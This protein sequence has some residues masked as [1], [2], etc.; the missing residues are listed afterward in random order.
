M[1]TRRIVFLSIF[2]IYQ[3]TVFLLTVFME[4]KKDDFGFLFEV[5]K[6]MSWFKYGALIGVAFVVVE[7][8]WVKREKISN[9]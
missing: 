7:F 2:G 3:L 9:N 5:Q 1:N 4:S 6:K 8:L